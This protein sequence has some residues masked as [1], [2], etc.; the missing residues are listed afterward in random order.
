M[1]GKAGLLGKLALPC[2]R[3]AADAKAYVARPGFAGSGK[4]LA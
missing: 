2:N 4:A 1:D 3:K